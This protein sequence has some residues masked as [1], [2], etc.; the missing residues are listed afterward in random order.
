MNTKE[1]TRI[2][3]HGTIVTNPADGLER[4]KAVRQIVESC[5]Y[6]KV[7]G[8]MLDLYSASAILKV[9]D[10]INEANQAKYRA[11]PVYR[12]AD[13]AFKVMSK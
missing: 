6:A 4:I 12:M 11:L 5:Q 2:R 13:I 7:D 1:Q 9:Y 3:E 8:I 10:A